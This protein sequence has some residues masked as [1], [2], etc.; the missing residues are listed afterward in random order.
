MSRVFVPQKP[1]A[2]RESI[3]KIDLSIAEKYGEIVY[4]F[5][6]NCQ[7]SHDPI[8]SLEKARDTLDDFDFN[9]DFYLVAGGDPFAAAICGMI[10]GQNAERDDVLHFNYLRYDRGFRGG[11]A[12]YI[13][14]RAS[15]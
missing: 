12:N 7:P 9:N 13:P 5:P 2:Q 11:E 6:D 4:V 8:G 15:I 3:S 14:V 1:S 10:L